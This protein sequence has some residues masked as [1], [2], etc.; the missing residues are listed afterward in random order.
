MVD[1]NSIP[2]DLKAVAEKYPKLHFI[3]NSQNLGFGKAHNLALR[4]ASNE[5]IL[6]LNPDT[7][8]SPGTL[9]ALLDFMKKNPE[10][11][12]LTPKLEL[13]NGQIDWSSHRG[14]PTPWASLTYFL[15]GVRR[16]YNLSNLD[17][18]QVHE[19][20][21]ISG[22]FFLTRK[23]VLEKLNFFDEDYFMYAEDI[24]LCFR[25]KNLGLKI[26]YYPKVA[27]FHLKGASSG[28]KAH[29]SSLSRVDKETK[30]KVFNA[31]YQT[32]LIF[33]RKHLAKNYPG[34]VNWLV[35]LGI[36]LKWA[37]S[38]RSLEV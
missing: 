33:Y 21:V 17:L 30:L 14:F 36:K 15:F 31:F 12:A 37:M 19:V 27:A 32:M 2:G 22:A 5:Y 16:F 3:L 35:Y 13:A 6:I 29:S 1:N 8:I 10:V 11:G 18:A 20:D 23:A 24:D 9:P 28:I 4:Q 38:K 7:K 34:W 26:I 25:I